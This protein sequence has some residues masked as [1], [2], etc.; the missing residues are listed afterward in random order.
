M[1]I[2]DVQEVT[3][4]EKLISFQETAMYIN[5]FHHDIVEELLEAFTDFT[6]FDIIQEVVDALNLNITAVFKKGVGLLGF[7]HEVKA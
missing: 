4:G 5:L 1:N 2:L 7:I 3:P 6:D